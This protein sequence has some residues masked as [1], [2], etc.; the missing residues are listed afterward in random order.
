MFGRRRAR[1]PSQ[2]DRMR[3][4]AYQ[5]KR[6]FSG[7]GLWLGLWGWLLLTMGVA[8]GVRIKDIAH[9]EGI[10]PNPLVGYGLVVGLN[11]TGDKKGTEFTIRSVVNMLRRLGVQVDPSLVNVKNVAAVMVTA[12]LPPFAPKGT[13]LDVVVSSIGDA[14]SLQGGTLLL[15]PLR[16]PDGEVYA[17]AQGPLSIGGFVGG[18]GANQVQKNHPTTGRIPRGA[19]VEREIPFPLEGQQVFYLDLHQRDF[20]TARNI[21]RS[22]NQALGGALAHAEHPGR[23][24]VEIP[25]EYQDRVVDLVAAVESLPVQVDSAARVVLNERTGTVVL[26]GNVQIRTVAVSHGNLIVQIRTRFEVSQPG[27]FSQGQTVVV[28][29]QE[30]QVEE[31]QARVFLIEETATVEDLVRALNAVGV[32]PRDLIAILQAIEAAGALQGEL[33]LL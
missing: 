33:Q 24:R 23:V 20:T 9:V 2:P 6:R 8:Q 26:G 18:G 15:T 32:T 1:P 22:I 12:T 27:P 17:V 19:V 16:G 25:P 14:T 3:G 4:F 21:A 28:P 29:Q 10:H 7:I 5:K 11:G 31:P 30:V 13:R